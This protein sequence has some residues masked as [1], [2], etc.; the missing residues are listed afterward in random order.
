MTSPKLRTL[1]VW[2]WKQARADDGWDAWV[3]GIS[4][5]G[6]GAHVVYD[7]RLARFVGHLTV[8]GHIVH[9]SEHPSLDGAQMDLHNALTRAILF[10]ER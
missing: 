7:H 2:E 6:Y 10:R 1:P 9:A 3:H 8:D 4:G 5:I